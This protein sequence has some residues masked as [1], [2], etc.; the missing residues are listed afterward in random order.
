MKKIILSL[1]GRLE[2]KMKKIILLFFIL[3]S[4]SLNSAQAATVVSESSFSGGFDAFTT[5][6]RTFGLD[7]GTNTVSGSLAGT[8]VSGNCNSAD[9]GTGNTQDTFNIEIA[10][11]F[12][13]D[14]LFVTTSNVTGPI[15]FS[16]SFSLRNAVFSPTPTT[17]FDPFLPLNSTTVNLVTSAVSPGIYSV[18]MFGQQSIFSGGDFALDY[19]INFGVSA[20][21]VP[22][23]V[24]LFGSGLIGL[25]SI[26]R[27][28]NRISN[29]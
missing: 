2:I 10:P 20:V 3:C 22:A 11:G 25:I 23:A 28:K 29:I 7:S 12:K 15:D 6:P 5:F 18:S 19:S 14:S 8:C 1:P 21:P 9:P 27:R 17:I 26:A 16:A 24:W 13:L 4:F